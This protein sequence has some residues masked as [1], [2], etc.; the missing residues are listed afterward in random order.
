MIALVT[1]G[2]CTFGL[3]QTSMVGRVGNADDTADLT[4]EQ[5]SVEVT[6]VATWRRL[7]G[8]YEGGLSAYTVRERRDDQAMEP[9]DLGLGD[10]SAVGAGYMF[11]LGTVTVSPFVS[12]S[13]ALAETA[14]VGTLPDEE[15]S[16]STLYGGPGAGVEV[17]LPTGGWTPYTRLGVERMRGRVLSGLFEAGA[18]PTGAEFTTT[19]IL[20]TVGVR[21][22][23]Y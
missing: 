1:A 21:G 14:L 13:V 3:S 6:M 17:L 22:D 18:P 5:R 4:I 7:F 9:D 23:L 10:R 12:Y 8:Y 15:L 16:Q 20:F 19:A 2:G 11:P